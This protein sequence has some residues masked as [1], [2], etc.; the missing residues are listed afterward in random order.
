MRY[1]LILDAAL[2]ALAGTLAV[3]LSVVWLLYSFHTD[4]SARV[5]IEM[6]MVAETTAGFA[7]LAL[8]LGLAFFSLL[9]RKSWR[10]WAQGGAAIGLLGGSLFL[11][12]LLTA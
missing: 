7:M 5:G 10:W 4:L 1:L 8:V 3:V 12:R 11:Y 2:F 6:Q 9:R